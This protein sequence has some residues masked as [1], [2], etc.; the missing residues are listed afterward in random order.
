MAQADLELARVR[1]HAHALRAQLRDANPLLWLGG[2]ALAGAL[3]ARI[4]GARRSGTGPAP[5]ALLAGL[6]EGYALRALK[7]FLAT[8]DDEP[9][10]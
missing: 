8:G 6:A 7:P 10:P 3:A 5:I 4:A 2:G 9:A 1:G